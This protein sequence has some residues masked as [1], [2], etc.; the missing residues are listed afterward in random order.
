[1]RDADLA[2]AAMSKHLSSMGKLLI[3]AVP[4]Q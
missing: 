4:H 2:R 1:L 3:Q